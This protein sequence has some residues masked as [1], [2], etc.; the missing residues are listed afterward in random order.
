MYVYLSFSCQHIVFFTI[1]N[2]C[3]PQDYLQ[4][5]HDRHE[6]WLG[7]SEHHSWHGGRPVLVSNQHTT[8]LSIDSLVICA[9]SLIVYFNLS[10]LSQILDSDKD[11]RDES[12]L[13]EQMRDKVVHKLLHDARSCS[14][15]FTSTCESLT[16]LS[17]SAPPAVVYKAKRNLHL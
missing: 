10:F 5:L 9:V 8:L 17:A 6:E 11:Y 16:P 15:Q 1:S 12:G 2:L 7:T 4:S 3:L 14:Q 13:F